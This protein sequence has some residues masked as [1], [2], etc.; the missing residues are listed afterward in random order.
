MINVAKLIQDGSKGMI[1]MGFLPPGH[2]TRNLFA[3]SHPTSSDTVEHEGDKFKTQ[4]AVEKKQEVIKTVEDSESEDYKIRHEKVVIN[5][6][7]DE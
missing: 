5:F 2:K 7:D 6:V 3:Y 1:K 4:K